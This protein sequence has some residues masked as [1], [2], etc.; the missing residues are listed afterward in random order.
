MPKVT[1]LT[2]EEAAQFGANLLVVVRHED[3]TQATAATAQTV[4]L[5][6][7]PALVQSVECVNVELREAFQD[8]TDAANNTTAVQVGDDGDTDRLLASTQLNVN[9]TEVFQKA[10]TGTKHVFSA[11]NYVDALFEAPAA[12]KTLLALNK[13]EVRFYFRLRDSR[14][15]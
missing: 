9:G 14:G 15:L 13:G 12:D 3:L 4:P 7:V 2:N 1:M 5:F 8:T 6:K 10:G 11:E